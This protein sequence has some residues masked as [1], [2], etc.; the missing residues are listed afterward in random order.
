MKLTP[1]SQ[2][3]TGTSVT[4][5]YKVKKKALPG[6]HE[7]VFAGRDADGRTRTATLTMTI[8]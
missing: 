5:D 1:A 7:L 8:Q 4:F 2:S 3:S 6:V